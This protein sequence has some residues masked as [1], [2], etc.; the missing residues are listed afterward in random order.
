MSVMLRTAPLTAFPKKDNETKKPSPGLLSKLPS[1][2]PIMFRQGTVQEYLVL[3]LHSFRPRR[4]PTQLEINREWAN[5]IQTTSPQKNKF[6]GISI[7]KQSF[8]KN[9]IVL[10]TC[11]YIV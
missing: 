11:I 4:K 7:G 5:S 2:H 1:R 8:F 6:N 10:G 3:N 9:H